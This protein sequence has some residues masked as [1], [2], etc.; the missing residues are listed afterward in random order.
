MSKAYLLSE[1]DINDLDPIAENFIDKASS[2]NMNTDNE[3][4]FPGFKDAYLL[5]QDDQGFVK[6][7]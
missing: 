3:N 2:S 5:S 4:V 1:E 7:D 6:H